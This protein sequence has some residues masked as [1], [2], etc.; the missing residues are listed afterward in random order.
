[1]ASFTPYK[2]GWRAFVLID[3]KRKSKTFDLKRAA[4][5]WATAEENAEKDRKTLPEAQRRTVAELLTKY[6]EDV[7]PAKRGAESDISRINA[8]LK[9]FPELASKKLANVDTPDFTKWREARSKVA[10][11]GTVLREITTF[12]H[13]FT[14]ARKEWRWIERNPLD[15][16]TRPRAPA[17]RDRRVSPSEVKRICRYLGYVTGV[18][19]ET[20]RQ[21]TALAFLV[22]LRSAMRA[23]EILSLSKHNLNVTKRVATVEHKTQNVTGKPRSVP[24][25]R[26]AVRLLRPV[27]MKERCF[28]ITPGALS[29]QFH[30]ACEKLAIK[31]IHFHDSRAEALTRLSR[32]VDVM[33]LAKISGHRDLS[34]LQNTYYRETAEDI[35]ARL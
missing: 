7:C 26:H 27:S 6:A 33:T 5:A 2:N 29:N 34:V 28:R 20:S 10:M 13:A 22:A 3:G 15:D 16:L 17:S 11:P 8:F 19:P 24:L 35:A 4:V 18:A 30:N 23:G 21:E 32:K 25:T 9:A 31:N 1:M 12:G 14:L